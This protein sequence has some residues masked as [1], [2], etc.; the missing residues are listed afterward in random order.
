MKAEE[1]LTFTGCG[2][3]S[4]SIHTIAGTVP[5][6]AT[7]QKTGNSDCNIIIYKKKQKKTRH[8]TKTA[9]TFQRLSTIQRGVKG[10]RTSRCT[11]A[12][13]MI[14]TR[15]T[16]SSRPPCA[17]SVCGSHLHPKVR[18]PAAQAANRWV[19]AT[20]FAHIN[21]L[22]M[23]VLPASLSNRRLLQTSGPDMW[24]YMMDICIVSSTG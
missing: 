7:V 1:Q 13:K 11:I 10:Q 12:L 17:S 5:S 9:L 20:E 22:N 19:S 2:G 4:C 21:R 6:I 15:S 23:A 18:I 16:C 14:L 3:K 8:A 24:S